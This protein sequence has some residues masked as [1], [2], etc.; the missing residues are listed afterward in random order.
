MRWLI[1]VLL[2]FLMPASPTYGRDLS[3]S[4]RFAGVQR[5]YHVHIPQ[6]FD[7]KH[8]LPVVIVFHSFTNDGQ[9]MVE[10]SGFNQ[11][12]DQDKFLVVYPEGI[13]RRWYFGEGGYKVDDVGFTLALLELMRTKFFADPKRTY[14]V[15]ISNG[16]FLVLTLACQ[17]P[18]QFAAVALVAAT[19]TQRQAKTC[20][21]NHP[22][23]ITLIHGEVDPLVPFR[24]GRTAEGL[25]LLSVQDTVKCWALLDTCENKPQVQQ[26]PSRVQDGTSVVQ[27]HFKK[28]RK[29]T[30]VQLYQIAGGGHTWPGSRKN[31]PSIV[32]GK[33]SQN[34]N[35]SEALWQFFHKF[36]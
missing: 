35:A 18:E 14:A 29:G 7:G 11:I 15:G 13:G 3:E 16:G 10:L 1:F 34:L 6:E 33:A 26:L 32:V 27:T 25:L 23:P 8:R 31:L 21:P 30:Q 36:P 2:L 12:A 28:C 19:F 22:V 4:I 20:K 17:H 9:S 24:G 5:F